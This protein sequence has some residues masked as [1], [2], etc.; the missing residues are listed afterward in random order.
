MTRV[1]SLTKSS[2]P[3]S[4]PENS[5]SLLVMIHIREPI[6]LSM[7]SALYISTW[8]LESQ[9]STDLMVIFGMPW[10]EMVVEA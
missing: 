9:H 10:R 8:I 3:V 1:Y 6:H 4:T 5:R 2:K 7:S